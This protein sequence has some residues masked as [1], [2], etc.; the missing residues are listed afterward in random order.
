MQSEAAVG[1][2]TAGRTTWGVVVFVVLAVLGVFIA[3][4]DPYYFKLLTV[5]VKHT[6]GAS[7]VTGTAAGAPPAGWAAA[8]TYFLDYFKDIWVALAAG[9]VIGAGVEV[10]LPRDWLLRVLGRADW[11]TASLAVAAAVPS[12]MC[13]CCSAPIAVGLARR[14]VSTA[15]VLAY[16]IGNPVLNPA[17]IVF[18]G[19]VL[20]WGWSLLRIGMGLAVVAGAVAI[21]RRYGSTPASDDLLASLPD[22]GETGSV[23][24]RFFRQLGRLMLTLLPEYVVIVGVLGAARAWLFPAMNPALGHSWW[25]VLF[26]AVAGTLFVIPT[27]GEIPIVQT[28]M[29]YGLGAAPAGTL[30]ITLPAVSLP[31][32]AMV[33]QAVPRA[34]LLRLA[35]WVAVA[36]VATGILAGWLL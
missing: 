9:L 15:S 22:E 33:S 11:G 5:S 8:I 34:V 18:M 32:L 13:T 23:V 6:L 20:G 19:F 16:W 17:T 31:S 14:R 12:M 3:K 21:G 2:K 29:T 4:W 36:G 25:L 26:F 35:A 7:I 30:M 24:V 28:L 10:L 1:F 27:A